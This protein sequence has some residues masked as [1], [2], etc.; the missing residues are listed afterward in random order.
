MSEEIQ[1]T[2]IFHVC[3]LMI[4]II[5]GY[6][7]KISIPY[8]LI[9]LFLYTGLFYYLIFFKGDGGSAFYWLFLLWITTLIHLIY[10]LYKI[11]YRKA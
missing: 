6:K 10:L 2:I 1:G 3:Q 5:M 8:H 7:R 11:F 9:I 4:I